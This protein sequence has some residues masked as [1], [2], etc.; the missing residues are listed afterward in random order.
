LNEVGELVRQ[1]PLSGGGLRS[2]GIPGEHDILP[3]GKRDRTDTVG[4]GRG[5]VVRVN[6]DPTEITAEAGLEVR[7]RVGIERPPRAWR[8]ER[9]G[10][11]QA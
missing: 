1:K 10:S 6:A 9:V 5:M 11:L 8:Y 3:G 2:K 4:R 7:A